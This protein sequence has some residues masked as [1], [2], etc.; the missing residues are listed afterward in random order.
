MGK[1]CL[2]ADTPNDA[3]CIVIPMYKYSYLEDFMGDV[4]HVKGVQRH[5]VPIKISCLK[6]QENER[7][8]FAIKDE[9][10]INCLFCVLEKPRDFDPRGQATMTPA[11]KNILTPYGKIKMTPENDCFSGAFL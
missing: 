9:I 10:C 11:G 3:P 4:K 2:Y 5:S 8:R 7:G 1:F 6:G